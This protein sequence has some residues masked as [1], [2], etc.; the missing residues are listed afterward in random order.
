[1]YIHWAASELDERYGIL[2]TLERQMGT[3]D[4]VIERYLSELPKFSPPGGRLVLA[5]TADRATGIGCFHPI[6]PEIA[7]LKRM[8]VQPSARGNGIGRA[9]LESLLSAARE[10]GYRRMRLDSAAFMHA[11]HSLYRSAGFVDI[12]PYPETEIP[13]DVRPHWVFM[14]RPLV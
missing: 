5:Y 3:V 1:M 14:E 8:Y 11:A 7:E 13:T 9:V 2:E 12:D 4:Q 6:S 10:A